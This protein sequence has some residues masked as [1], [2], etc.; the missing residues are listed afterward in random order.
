MSVHSRPIRLWAIIASLAIAAGTAAASNPATDTAAGNPHPPIAGHPGTVVLSPCVLPD[1]AQAARCGVLDVPENPD[2]PE[3]RRLS[4]GVAVVPASGSPVLPDPIVPLQGGPG[5][6]AIS[7]AALFADQFASLRRDRDLL[8]LDQRGTGRSAPLRCDLHSPEEPAASLR[9]FFPPDAVKRCE[10]LLRTRADLTQYTYAHFARDL[11]SVRKALGY[12]PLNL[13]A[14]S[15]GTRAA[16]VYL[17]AYP[18]SVRT[19]YLGSVVPIDVVTPLTMAK[20]AQET[21]ETTF[22]ACASDSTCGATFPNLRDEFTRILARL[23]AGEVRVTVPGGTGTVPMHRGRVVEWFRSRLYRPDTAAELPWLIHQAHEGN[24]TPIVEGVLS[25][26][27]GMDSANSL[28]LFF[29]ITCAEDI[30]FLHEKD[31]VAESR[32]TSL[33]DYR[34]LQQRGACRHWPKASLPAEYRMPVRSPVPT[35][36]VS[37]DMDGGSPLWF[38]D[39]VATGFSDRH[40]VVL[41][42]RGHTEWSECVAQLYERFVRTGA[43]RELDGSSCKATPRPPFKVR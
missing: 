2:L 25:Q 18:N 3:G 1:L 22:N 16:Q 21:L 20:T 10:R 12:G 17:R 27:Q 11:E 5:E 8:L 4:I 32:G 7:A 40:E 38:T 42:G 9:D 28:G 23:D 36:F 34:V 13:F 26:A 31:I 15:Y 37:G 35:L 41:R 43:T 6:D 33:G 19:A 30:A 24:W 29:S 39:H 14:G